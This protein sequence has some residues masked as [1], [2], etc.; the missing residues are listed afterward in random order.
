M[1]L[2]FSR[3]IFTS[4]ITLQYT[5]TLSYMYIVYIYE[6]LYMS[7]AYAL[8]FA[9]VI[10]SFPFLTEEFS[11]NSVLALAGGLVI[12]YLSVSFSRSIWFER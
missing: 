6:F 7:L 12:T 3:V 8:A 4:T 1:Y 2:D 10:I 5:Y 11:K 9:H